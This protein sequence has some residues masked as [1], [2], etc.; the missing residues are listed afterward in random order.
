MSMHTRNFL[1]V[2]AHFIYYLYI[3]NKSSLHERSLPCTAN[4]KCV[5]HSVQLYINYSYAN[6]LRSEMLA[7]EF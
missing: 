6:S 3:E 2:H 7:S 4:G 1:C 5:M